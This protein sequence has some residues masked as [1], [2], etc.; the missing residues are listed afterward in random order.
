MKP[1]SL[2]HERKSSV[3]VCD[4][5]RLFTTVVHANE[6]GKNSSIMSIA[7]VAGRGERGVRA[8]AC[9]EGVE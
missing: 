8:D 6:R 4:V 2:R 1:A 3:C 5:A 7:A 9:S